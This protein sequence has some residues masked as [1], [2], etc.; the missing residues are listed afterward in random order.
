M[1]GFPIWRRKLIPELWEECLTQEQQ[2]MWLEKKY[3]ELKE[4]VDELDPSSPTNIDDTPVAFTEQDTYNIQSGNTV[5]KLF[6]K[7]KHLINSLKS[8][9]FTASY[10]DLIDAPASIPSG[11]S[12]FSRTTKTGFPR[13]GASS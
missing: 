1:F 5:S 6:G 3:T 13:E 4:R 12:V 8:V 7:I 11:R 9:A 10:N 2:F